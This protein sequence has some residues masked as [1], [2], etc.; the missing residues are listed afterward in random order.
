[1][2]GKIAILALFSL[3]LACKGS[4][5]LKEIRDFKNSEWFIAKKETFE[6]EVKDIQK[7]YDF[8]YLVRNTV[9]YP[10][11]NLYLNQTLTDDKG[12]VLVNSMDEVILFNQKTGKPYGDGMGDIFDN[13]VAAPKLQ[14]YKFAKSGKYKWTIGHNMRPD[15]L[16]GMMSIGAEVL[17]K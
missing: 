9:S 7:V 15:P 2:R 5:D 4:S 12:K 17:G 6:F 1:M 10:Y 8:N 11:Y 16:Q 13:R 14:K 3:I